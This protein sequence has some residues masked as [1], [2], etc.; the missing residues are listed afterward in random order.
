MPA[1][2]LVAST[3]ANSVRF[4]L[5]TDGVLLPGT[6]PIS[7]VPMLVGL[8]ADEGSAM[9]AGY[10]DDSQTALHALLTQTYGSMADRFAAL[11][12]SETASQRAA[13]NRQVR[14]DRGLGAIYA[15]AKA[16]P[17][18]RQPVYVYRYDHVEPGPQSAR[19]RAFHSSEIP[20]VFQTFGASPERRFTP[21]DRAL[22]ARISR[23]WLNFIRTG[24]PNG[25]AL[26]TWP[27][28]D[29]TAPSILA[30]GEP[31]ARAPLLPPAIF[32]AMQEFLA[33]GGRPA[34]F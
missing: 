29:V 30:I 21:Q 1:E 19:W 8:N 27:K 13:A 16:R 31:T 32:A 4:G 15:W 10:G 3:G 17:G 25:A 26:P 14:R 5:V 2:T 24:D 23:S 18:L 28:L 7:D 22:S 34:I 9:S 20:Y 33:K 12:P 11:Y 6:A